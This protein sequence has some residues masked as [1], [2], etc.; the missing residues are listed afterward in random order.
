M[1]IAVASGKGGTGKT[2]VATNLAFVAA[3][4]GRSVVYVD[5]D[6]EEPNGH[7]FLKPQITASESVGRLI[8]RVDLQTCT[9]CG[10]CGQICQYSAIAPL[11]DDVLVFPEL[12]HS[13]GGCWLVCPV[14]AIGEVERPTGRVETGRAGEVRFVQGVLNVGEARSTPVIQAAKAASPQVDLVILDAP[15]GTSC[16]V[17]EVVRGADFALLVG[18]PT[19]FGL[20]DF[21]LAAAMLREIGI[22]FG[23]AVNRADL[24]DPEA[25]SFYRGGRA[26]V[27]AEI[28]DDRRVAEA[29]SRG[30]LACEVVDGYRALFDRL[31]A[32][33]LKEAASAAS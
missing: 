11:A 29:Y 21:K 10:Q 18:E 17:I 32:G 5:C 8:P 23:V 24:A 9:F 30:R 13:C 14:G 2:T 20:N 25:L 15:P 27:L 19:P 4:A 33:L 3:A 16:P 6:V 12:C 22:R 26:P 28:P 31:L 1:K 7:L